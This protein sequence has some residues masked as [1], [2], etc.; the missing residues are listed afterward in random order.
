MGSNSCPACSAAV[1]AGA[2]WCS[3]CYARLD[4]ALTPPAPATPTRAAGAG[5]GL[6][7]DGRGG[8]A[9]AGWPCSRC[10]QVNGLSAD[11]CAACGGAF[12]AG[13][14]DAEAPLLVLPG[15]GDVARLSRT[16]RA[17]VA[18]GVALL[19]IAAA[20]AVLFALDLLL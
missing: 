7:G 5:V 3:L 19:A 9:G 16:A 11:V 4:A 18:L 20:F 14:R 1:P 13:V 10:G 15:V 6:A 12:L 8:G 2:A 17:G